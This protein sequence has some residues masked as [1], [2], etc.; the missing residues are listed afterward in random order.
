M[1]GLEAATGPCAGEGVADTRS[2][3]SGS[4][5]MS[6]PPPSA[7]VLMCHAPIVIPSIGKTRAEEC[8]ATTRAME[9]AAQTVIEAN[10]ETVLLLS[11]HTPRHRHAYGHVTGQNLRGDFHAFGVTGHERTFRADAAGAATMAR[12]MERAGLAMTPTNSP[13]LDHGA[14]VP[15]WFLHAAGFR[16]RVVVFGFPWESGAEEN[17]RFGATLASAMASMERSWALVASGDMSHALK[18]G[19]PAGFHPQAHCFDEEVVA[20]VQ[21]GRLADVAS[22]DPGLKHLAAEDVTESLAAADGALGPAGSQCR[23]LSYEAPFGVGYL[24]ALLRVPS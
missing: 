11:P 23:V 6:V 9:A 1:E 3:D 4:L 12:H 24:V 14:F 7:A 21:D 5:L 17:H 19:A 10:V 18:E 22:I 16:G 15:L 8:A 2:M 20:C 13:T